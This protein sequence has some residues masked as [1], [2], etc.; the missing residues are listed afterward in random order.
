MK[1]NPTIFIADDDEEDIAL[2]R[3][4]LVDRNSMASCV[5][6][7]N[8]LV[9]LNYLKMSNQP[10]PD[11]IVLDINMP[12]K[13]GFLTLHELQEDALLQPIPVI[14]LTSSVRPEDQ[15]RCFQ[16]GCK[17]FLKKPDSIPDFV[18]LAER[19]LSFC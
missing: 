13:N 4:S 14:M 15:T 16:M 6:F 7:H 18:H 10:L 12:V 8:G 17:A 11:L 19:I 9:L 1:T 2:L 5:T 3:D